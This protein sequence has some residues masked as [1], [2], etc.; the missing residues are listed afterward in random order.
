MSSFRVTLAAF[1]S[2]PVYFFQDWFA[3]RQM[4]AQLEMLSPHLLSD[5]GLEHGEI[6]AYAQ[7]AMRNRR[8]DPAGPAIPASSALPGNAPLSVQF[9]R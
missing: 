5:I 8:P 7:R 4:V 3:T 9:A 2:A 6:R 1:A